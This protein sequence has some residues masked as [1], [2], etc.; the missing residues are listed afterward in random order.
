[1]AEEVKMQS[2]LERLGIEERNE[3][4]KR[5]DYTSKEHSGDA[6]SEYHA[7][8]ADALSPQ[9][10]NAK[11]EEKGKGTNS[12][13]GYYTL[14]HEKNPKSGID[15]SKV[16]TDKGG[17]VVD[18]ETRNA[19]FLR[20]LYSEDHFYGLNSVDTSKNVADGQFVVK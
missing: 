15:Y 16:V 17:G 13:L 8:H 19:H 4:L 10:P 11:G 3:E 5:A 7:G 14:S 18:I 6:E 2:N 9:T 1:M 12:S 20:N